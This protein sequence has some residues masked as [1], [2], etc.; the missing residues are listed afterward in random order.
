[1]VIVTFVDFVL[2]CS[3]DGAL[4]AGD[5]LILDNAPV[6]HGE[7]SAAF[8][9]DI[10]EYFSVKLVYL[11][12]YSPELNPCELVFALIKSHVQNNNSSTGLADDVA[13]AVATVT[14]E[15]VHQY[16]L[17]CIFPTVVLPDLLYIHCLQV[18][19]KAKYFLL[20]KNLAH[21]NKL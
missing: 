16:Y 1:M 2:N 9:M 14:D 19:H 5:Y 15:Q 18:L 6:H 10:L 21:V 4:V 11:P 17:H 13:A 7:E 12:A 8:L 20:Q 3:L